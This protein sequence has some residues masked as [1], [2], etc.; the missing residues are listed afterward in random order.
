M[1]KIYALK[2]MPRED[3]LIF[4]PNVL[5]PNFPNT[6]PDFPDSNVVIL[7][8]DFEVIARFP[9]NETG[10]K[11]SLKDVA[12]K[13]KRYYSA[14]TEFP[15]SYFVVPN[16]EE[17]SHIFN[18]FRSLDILTLVRRRILL[19]DCNTVIPHHYTDYPVVFDND[20]NTDFMDI[21]GDDD[22]R[23]FLV[24]ELNLTNNG[25]EVRPWKDYESEDGSLSLSKI[26]EEITA[27]SPNEEFVNRMMDTI[28]SFK[29][30]NSKKEEKI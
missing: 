1:S 10:D 7:T 8:K 28:E 6:E 21:F 2:M 16:V 13:A 4:H 24:D 19:K 12:M 25:Y 22:F 15:F 18:T 23:P 5:D 30:A 9:Y 29:Q 11:P 20:Y 27:L 3:I 26:M 17:V 14:H